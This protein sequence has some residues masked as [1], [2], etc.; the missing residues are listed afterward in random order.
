MTF[1]GVIKG[2]NHVTRRFIPLFA[3]REENELFSQLPVS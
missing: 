3:E 1:L 2:V